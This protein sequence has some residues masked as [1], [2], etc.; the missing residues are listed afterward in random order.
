MTQGIES[1]PQR[2]QLLLTLY[3]REDLRLKEISAIIG[4]S[5]SRISRLL[6][7]ALFELREY[8]RARLEPTEEEAKTLPFDGSRW[9]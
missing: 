6:A 2:Q 7:A 4:L 5:E 8:L 3:Y 9:D 1:L